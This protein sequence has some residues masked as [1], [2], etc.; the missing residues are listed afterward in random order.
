MTLDAAGL[1]Q[2]AL[3]QG[4][5]NMDQMSD[6]VAETDHFSIGPLANRLLSLLRFEGTKP[7]ATEDNENAMDVD[8]TPVPNGDQQEPQNSATSFPELLNTT[9]GRALTIPR[10]D[11]LQ[12]DE[13]IRAELRY[14]GMMSMDETADYD[15]HHDD[16]IAER[17]RA[18]QGHLKKQVIVNGAR[19]T[20]MQEMLKE[21]MAYQE[22]TTIHDDLDS[23][24]QQAYLKRTRTLG[25][26]K[27]GSG[28]KNRPGANAA[29][30]A[31]SA[32][33]VGRPGLG[34]VAKTLMERRRRW[35]D[36]IGPVFQ[37]MNA[38]V[39]KK[40]DSIYEPAVMAGYEKAE[41][42]GLDEA[43]E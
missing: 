6:Q 22:Y 20:R 43:D 18:L 40:G 36:C 41:L 10:L 28:N 33:G 16:D 24:V 11:H 7:S 23:Q 1:E 27:K 32:A 19:K 42:E 39:P 25:K 37:D 34:D 26:S 31:G 29:G 4:R 8:S 15:D 14:T 21:R 17:L 2:S 35:T 12:L 9:A 30:A 5:G 13:R 3:N 38:T